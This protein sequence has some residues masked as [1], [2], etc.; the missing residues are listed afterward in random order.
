MVLVTKLL[1]AFGES[2]DVMLPVSLDNCF[3]NGESADANILPIALNL[4]PIVKPLMLKLGFT[5][6]G[7]LKVGNFN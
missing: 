4:P 6:E 1:I 3:S 2:A 7:S 5:K